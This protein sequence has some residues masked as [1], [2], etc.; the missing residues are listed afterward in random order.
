MMTYTVQ[1]RS[2]AQH[3]QDSTAEWLQVA[4]IKISL[5]KYQTSLALYMYANRVRGTEYVVINL[6]IDS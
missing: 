2:P 5:P 4:D 6:P 3:I 1:A